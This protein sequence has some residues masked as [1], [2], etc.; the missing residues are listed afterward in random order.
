MNTRT[1]TFVLLS[2]CLA[3]DVAAAAP[4]DDL[5]RQYGAEGAGPFTEAAG[6]RLWTQQHPGSDAPRSCTSCHTEDPRKTGRHAA[7]GKVIEPLAPSV[8]PNRLS[9][10]AK[11]EKWLLRNCKWTLGRECTSQEKV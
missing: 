6:E 2:T 5:L 8:K 11:I 1:L 4:I 10:R 9:E 7:T 3:Q